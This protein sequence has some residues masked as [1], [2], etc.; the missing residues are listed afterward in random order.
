[1][2]ENSV[3]D[4]SFVTLFSGLGGSLGLWLG[5]G[6]LQLLLMM[7]ERESGKRSDSNLQRTEEVNR[8][9]HERLERLERHERHERLERVGVYS[10]AVI[11]RLVEGCHVR[12]DN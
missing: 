2:T 9:C 1:M 3:P 10:Q 4:F 12:G 6:V 7:P 5:L 11:G 8:G